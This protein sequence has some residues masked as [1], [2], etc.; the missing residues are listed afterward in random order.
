MLYNRFGNRALKFYLYIFLCFI[1]LPAA[2][3]YQGNYVEYVGRQYHETENF[4]GLQ[5]EDK[6]PFFSCIEGQEL[7]D[8]DIVVDDD[9]ITIDRLKKIMVKGVNYR[10]RKLGYVPLNG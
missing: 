9:R 10:M 4:P 2:V 3:A 7:K 8:D 1:N 6:E 5:E